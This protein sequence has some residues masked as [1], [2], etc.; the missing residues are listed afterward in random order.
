MIES[1]VFM[2]FMI[3]LWNPEAIGTCFAK[4]KIDKAQIIALIDKCSKQ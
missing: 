1:V 3:A 2:I 4:M